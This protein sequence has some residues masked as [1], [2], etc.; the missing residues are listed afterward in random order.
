MLFRSARSDISSFGL[1]LYELLTGK[2]AMDGSSPASVIAAI[3][4]RPAPS[5]ADVAPAALDR[6]LRKC[7][8][9][10]PDDRWQ[11]ARDL[12]D[13]LEWIARP[14]EVAVSAAA[15]PLKFR[16]GGLAWTA[17]GVLA[18]AASAAGFGWWRA[19]QP[20]DRPLVRLSVDL[21]PN[22]DRDVGVSAIL[23]PDG[24]RVVYVSKG[25]GESHQ[26]YTRRLDQPVA[27][28][29]TSEPVRAA[30][31]EIGRAHV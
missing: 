12:K 3:M 20:Q 28:L 11:T 5:I 9:K 13:E 6:A 24:S 22:A 18:I 30:M 15:A 31:P 4:E 2:R 27:T 26:L 29:L 1:V 16:V 14:P 23:S 19:S 25:P 10:D 17:A 21:G 7:L 8:A